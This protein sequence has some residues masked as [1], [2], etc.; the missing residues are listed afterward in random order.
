MIV[1]Q[2]PEL[3]Q[4]ISTEQLGE[5]VVVNEDL[6]NLVDI[7]EALE[8]VYTQNKGLENALHSINDVIGK[9]IVVNR[10]YEPDSLGITK[11]GTE[12]GSIVRKIKPEL[13]EYS[14]NEA[15][16]LHDGTSYDDHIYYQPKASVAFFNSKSA[17]S[18]KT[19]R[20]LKQVKSAFKSPEAAAKFWGGIETFVHNSYRMANS[21]L[22]QR[23]VNNAIAETLY[24]SFS[25]GEYSGKSSVKAVNL[26]Y[27]YNQVFEQSLTPA[28]ALYNES[29]LRFASSMIMKYKNRVKHFSTLFNVEGQPRH[30]PPELLHI[31]LLTDFVQN[32]NVYLQSNVFHN[33]LT[34]LPYAREVP[35]W[36]GSGTDFSFAEVSK[37]DVKTSSGNIV[38]APYILGVAFD[39]DALG[40]YNEDMDIDTSYTASASF[41]TTF[42]K[43]EASY[44]NALDENIVV[45]YLA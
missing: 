4:Q 40:V 35:Y 17:Y 36:Q 8:N 12:Y 39:H 32:V 23:T 42:Y 2:L 44:Y 29:F 11:S 20:G 16:Q 3:L 14:E 13:P 19:S 21:A 45:F 43:W 41:F 9:D 24:S 26:L 6:S 22:E 28:Q 1:Q 27:E 30:T 33:E 15:W 31:I 5:G 18:I 10:P 37:I 7:G 38:T 25:D 34:S